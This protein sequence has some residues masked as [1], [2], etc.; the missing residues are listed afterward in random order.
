MTEHLPRRPAK[1]SPGLPPADLV[2]RYRG[3]GDVLQVAG[4]CL[5][6]DATES[7]RWTPAALDSLRHKYRDADVVCG[8]VCR[9]CEDAA[10]QIAEQSARAAG[11]PSPAVVRAAREAHEARNRG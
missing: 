7:S 6:C 2:R 10:E 5:I 8:Y 9:D 3:D 11:G 4:G 1:P